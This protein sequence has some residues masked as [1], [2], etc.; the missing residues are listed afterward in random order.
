[1]EQ[2]RVPL[3]IP[4]SL[5]SGLFLLEIHPGKE[6]GVLEVTKIEEGPVE[7][8]NRSCGMGERRGYFVIVGEGR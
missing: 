6:L 3:G 4:V 2:G 7:R 5:S 1:M 8:E